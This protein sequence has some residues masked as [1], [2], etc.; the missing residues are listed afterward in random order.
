MW[1]G[2]G[3][4][5]PPLWTWIGAALFTGISVLAFAIGT[6]V[7]YAVVLILVAIVLIAGFFGPR[8]RS[9]G[10]W[11]L[12]PPPDRDQPPPGPPDR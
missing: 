9:G 5:W 8:D 1:L 3:W 2:S 11:S 4:P 7:G 6:D 12:G 10:E